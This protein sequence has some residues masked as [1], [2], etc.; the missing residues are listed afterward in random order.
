MSIWE[1]SVDFHGQITY[2]MIILKS[3]KVCSIVLSINAREQV[4][5]QIL[6]LVSID[7][8]EEQDGF[9]CMIPMAFVI[10]G[11][12]CVRSVLCR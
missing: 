9:M 10:G 6:L 5:L 1:K 11:K 4:L 7:C 12:S 8:Q 2:N 3:D